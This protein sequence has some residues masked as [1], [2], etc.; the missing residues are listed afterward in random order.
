VQLTS[1]HSHRAVSLQERQAEMLREKIKALESRIMDMV[2][3]GNENAHVA[4]LQRL[5]REA[6]V[7]ERQVRVLEQQ[8]LLGV[9]RARFRGGDAKETRVK[10]LQVVNEAAVPHALLR[11]LAQG[12]VGR[13]G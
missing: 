11:L 3:N 6:S 12:R 4:T 8:A 10:Q 1:P 7:D 9:H 13:H 5:L 2:R